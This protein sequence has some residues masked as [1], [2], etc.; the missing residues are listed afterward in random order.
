DP[1][2]LEILRQLGQI[3]ASQDELLGT[4]R[5]VAATQSQSVPSGLPPSD[6]DHTQVRSVGDSLAWDDSAG[7]HS[8]QLPYATNDWFSGQADSAST[9][10]AASA[11]AAAVRWFDLLANDAPPE[12]FHEPDVPLGPEAGF[13][14]PSDGQDESDMTPLQRATRMIDGQ[15]TG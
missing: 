9:S 15:P 7:L 3:I 10:P 11:S 4:V 13:L 1:A 8:Q 5:S 2:S 6:A 12:A 14:D